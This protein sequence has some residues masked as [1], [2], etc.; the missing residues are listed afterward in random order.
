M[1]R[2]IRE[3]GYIFH[4]VATLRE[5]RGC[6]TRVHG[7]LGIDTSIKQRS[8][9]FV[10]PLKTI[11][12]RGVLQARLYSPTSLAAKRVGQGRESKDGGGGSQ[13]GWQE[14]RSG[15]GVGGGGRSGG[16]RGASVDG[17]CA[18]NERGIEGTDEL[19]GN[20][21]AHCTRE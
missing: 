6:S 16:I 14:G 2:D 5:M 3:R 18:L 12:P 15:A 9:N 17:Q 4:I 19:E 10:A 11:V 20:L 13:G 7:K 21:K 8:H 1:L